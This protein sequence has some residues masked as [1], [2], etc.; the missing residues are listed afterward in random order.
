MSVVGSE[1]GAAEEF[2]DGATDN[3]AEAKVD[4]N[5]HSLEIAPHAKSDADEAIDGSA[6]DDEVLDKLESGTFQ[7]TSPRLNW[8]NTFSPNEG[9]L[10]FGP[11]SSIQRI[12]SLPNGGSQINRPFGRGGAGRRSSNAGSHISSEA[13]E[14]ARAEAASWAQMTPLIAATLGPLSVLLGIPTLTQRWHGRV[15]DPPTKTNGVSNFEELPDPTVNLVLAG[16][17][18]FCEVMGNGLLIL[19]FS[20]FHTKVTTWVSYAFWWAKILLGVINYIQF[21]IAHPETDD[22]IYLQGFWVNH[23]EVGCSDY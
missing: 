7:P 8:Q 22:I 9:K 18:L 20:N 2:K 16:I 13:V 4:P 23:R 12:N 1:F 17:S 19:R 3:G 6:L 15:L 5:V 14:L 21:G 11:V 10:K